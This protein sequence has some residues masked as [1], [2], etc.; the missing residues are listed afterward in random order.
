MKAIRNFVVLPVVVVMI[1]SSC[2]LFLDNTPPTASLTIH[3]ELGTTSTIF[4]CNATG[5]TDEE[6]PTSQL[7]VQW[8][9]EDDGIW[10]TNSSTDK[11]ES[12][13][14]SSAG[15]YTVKL[16]VRDE[17]GLTGV[18]TKDVSV[19]SGGTGGDGEFTYDGRTYEYKTIGSQTWM[20]ENLAYLPSVSSSSTG[21]DSEKHYYVYGYEGTSVSAAKSTDNYE[22][23]GVLYN[24]EAAKTACPAG[25]RLPSDDD[26]KSLE[27]HL[28]MSYT[29]ANISGWRYSGDVGEKLMSTSGW[30]W[31]NDGTGT[32]SSGFTA[33]PGGSRDSNGGF[34][35]LNSYAFFW[36][37]MEPRWMYAWGRILHFLYDGVYRGRNYRRDGL[38]I[39]CIKN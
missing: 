30:G 22:T 28:G 21:S 19:T 11:T 29:D 31:H 12:H 9:W 36:S 7:E 18:I 13:Q 32:N 10:D 24:W 20:I 1:V 23:Y 2:E 37:F 33:L 14:F 25:W 17:E 3:P 6:T 39:R 27:K 4:V 8:D 5:C 16:E 15:T 26:W 38:S 34:Y 35:L